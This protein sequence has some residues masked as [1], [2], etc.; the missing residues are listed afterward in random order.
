MST[1]DPEHRASSPTP[2]EPEGA[3]EPTDPT[4]P[5]V[6]GVRGTQPTPPVGSTPAH[7]PPPPPAAPPARQAPVDWPAGSSA[8]QH[9]DAAT[10]STQPAEPDQARVPQTDT[11]HPHD[12]GHAPDADPVGS[13]EADTARRS[14]D[15]DT[16]RPPAAQPDPF[17]TREPA[18]EPRRGAGFGG[19]LLGILI[20][21]VLSVFALVLL[22]LGEARILGSEDPTAA[23]GIGIVL[24]TLAA[25]LLAMVVYLGVWTAALPITGG[26]VLTVIGGFYLYFPSV[27]RDETLR[28]LATDASRETVIY[29]IIASTMGMTFVVGVLL[30]VAGWALAVARRRGRALGAFRERQ[31]TP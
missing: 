20:G 27:A 11:A 31:R 3:P 26:V 12:T 19:H 8:K 14:P 29:G 30:L 13:L 21:A 16:A 18:K 10:H 5:T 6:G 22:L 28:L 15:A 25:L 9:S 7:E 4:G 23:D 2:A 1:S 24:V 17:P